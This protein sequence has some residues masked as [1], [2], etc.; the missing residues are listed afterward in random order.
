MPGT[1]RLT[2]TPSK[3]WRLHRAASVGGRV[4]SRTGH[5]RKDCRAWNESGAVPGR[6]GPIVESQARIAARIWSVVT[7]GRHFRGIVHLVDRPLLSV[8]RDDIALVKDTVIHAGDPCCHRPALGE[9]CM[10]RA[11]GTADGSFQRA[12]GGKIPPVGTVALIVRSAPP[13]P[14]STIN[15]GGVVGAF[16]TIC[17]STARHVPTTQGSI[18]RPP[19]VG[20]GGVGFGELSATG[21]RDGCENGPADVA[22]RPPIVPP[23]A[24]IS[25]ARAV[26]MPGRVVQ[27]E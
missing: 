24:V 5:S 27:K 13:L 4:R 3:P 15:F 16:T 2:V 17:S 1:A 25:A 20:G 19:G 7:P 22:A 21:A 26:R 11:S 12:V 9:H 18:A 14:L 10:G 6:G 8:A 23:T